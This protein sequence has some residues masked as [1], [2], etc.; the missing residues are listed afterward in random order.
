MGGYLRSTGL[1]LP[2]SSA[3][4]LPG[5]YRWEAID[6]HSRAVLT[7]KTPAATFRGPGEVES[8]FVRERLLDMAADE[9]GL[10]PLEIRRRNLVPEEELPYSFGYGAG[11]DGIED[12]S[13][14]SGGRR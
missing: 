9:V 8:T 13:G 12:W 3:I 7:N 2:E 1:V 4:H 14:G 11:G 10:T 5:P 6:V